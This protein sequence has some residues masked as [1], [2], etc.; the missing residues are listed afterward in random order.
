MKAYREQGFTVL[1]IVI[2]LGIIALFI[3]LPVFSYANYTKTVRDNQRTND[4]NQV[5]AALEMYKDNFGVYP[6]DLDELVTEG[7]LPA[8]PVDPLLGTP[9][10]GSTGEQY[11]YTFESTDPNSYTLTGIM[12][13]DG[14]GTKKYYVITPV[15]GTRRATMPT[16]NPSSVIPTSRF[17]TSTPVPTAAPSTTPVP[18][19]RPVDL[20]I[21][22]ITRN[23]INFYATYCN[24]GEQTVSQTFRIRFTRVG[25]SNHI[26]TPASPQ[27]AVPAPGTC[28]T[29]GG[30][31]C[32]LLGTTCASASQITAEADAYRTVSETDEDNNTYTHS[33]S[34]QRPDLVVETITRDASVYVVRYC[35]IGEFAGSETF[36][37]RIRN[38]LTGQQISSSSSNQFTIPAP[39]ECA[40]TGG[41]S[42]VLIGSSCTD[43]IG[44]TAT[45][46]VDSTVTEGDETNNQT[47]TNF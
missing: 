5:Q 10:D 18:T 40:S 14:Y 34:Q 23:D 2:A 6:E 3:F 28:A 4:L 38:N 19:Q 25:G 24:R 36:R 22:N 41:F 11:G 46:D 33:F 39:G 35:N 32:S 45:V 44:V 43:S 42:C 30:V 37:V 21:E 27:F 16:P 17:A 8:V 1:E 26:D 7:Y 15:G 29:T 47:T 13:D 31:N 12:E 9:V 20:T